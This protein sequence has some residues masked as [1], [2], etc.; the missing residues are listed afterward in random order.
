VK[1]VILCSNTLFKVL[2][3]IRVVLV[4]HCEFIAEDWWHYVRELP[5]RDA[6][7]QLFEV[8]RHVGMIG[9]S[10]APS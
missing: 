4:K 8:S 1:S 2:S 6:L 7:D 5:G 3:K 9:T 10:T